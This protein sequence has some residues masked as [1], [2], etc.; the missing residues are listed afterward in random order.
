[1]QRG[2]LV[3]RGEL[4]P[5]SISGT[6]QDYSPAG[7][8]RC[9]RLI[10]SLS[11]AASLGGLAFGFEG[12]CLPIFNASNFALTLIHQATGSAAGNRFN[13]ASS[14]NLVIPAQGGVMLLAQN[15]RWWAL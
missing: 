4:S 6:V 13:L 9:G 10:M 5:A 7:L 12:R 2:P 11:A 8:R 3:F 15:N 14:T 1:V